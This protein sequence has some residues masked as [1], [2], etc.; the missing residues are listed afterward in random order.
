MPKNS[1]ITSKRT[2]WNTSAKSVGRPGNPNARAGNFTV[3]DA[4]TLIQVG[5]TPTAVF[6]KKT[7]FDLQILPDQNPLL[8]VPGSY[9]TF[10]VLFRGKPLS[11]ATVRHWHRTGNGEVNLVFQTSDRR[12]R[13]R[14]QVPEGEQMVSL[15]HMIPHPN[16]VEADWQSTWGSLTWMR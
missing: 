9:L 8:V 14:F 12:G 13:V 6:F 16:P 4:A 1:I 10:Q 2:G 15:V 11:G 5:S 7:G 3:K